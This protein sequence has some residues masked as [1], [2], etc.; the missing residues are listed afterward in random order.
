MKRKVYY[1]GGVVK[2]AGGITGSRSIS[3]PGLLATVNTVP[4][5]EEEEKLNTSCACVLPK[6]IVSVGLVMDSRSRDHGNGDVV[7]TL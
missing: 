6:E 4:N 2:A 5:P 3:F 7:A 1:E